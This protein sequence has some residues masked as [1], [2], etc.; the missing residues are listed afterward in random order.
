MG[1]LDLSNINF[2]ILIVVSVLN[3]IML[4]LASAKLFQILQQ[5]GYKLRGYNAW[6]KDTKIKFVGRLV[7]LSF[8]SLISVLVTN[9]LL[10]GFGEYYSYFG[11]IFYVYFSIVF[12]I[13]MS[14]IPQKAPLKQTR[15]MNRLIFTT[16]ILVVIV[17]FFMMAITTEYVSFIKYG[18]IVLTPLFMPIIVPFANILNTPME[19]IIRSGYI[20]KAKAK[21][22]RMPNLIK[23]GITGSYGKTTTKHILNV[24]LSKKYSVCMTPHSFNTPMGLTKV[25]L[26]YL[27]RNNQILI[28]EMGARHIGDIKY[29]CDL[30]KPKHAIITSVASQHLLT[31]G[32]IEN[33]AK[34]KGELVEAITDGYV[35]FNGNNIGSKK[36]YDECLKNKILAGVD[37]DGA[38][39]NITN[40]KCTNT[41]SEFNLNVDG[42]SVVCSTKLLGMGNIQDIAISAAL[43]YKL[44]VELQDI[45]DAISTLQPIQHR[46]EIINNIGG[47]TII[48]NS[49]NSSV[50]ST[51]TSLDVLKLFEGKKIIVTPGIVEMGEK[52]FDANVDFG[53]RIAEIC[54]EVVILN[55]VNK[56][57]ILQGLKNKKFD[58]NNIITAD[59]L[60]DAKKKFPEIAGEGDVILFENDLPDNYT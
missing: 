39:V 2:Y 52:E 4:C 29:L 37:L 60:S 3:S 44:G 55:L 41:G 12:I 40:V 6:L 26:K 27:K 43:A 21:L 5:S 36:M 57:A 22:K 24:M 38:F 46:L 35:V 30:I 32:S 13:N 18:I 23:I 50:E 58:E 45:A 1:I 15:R 10:D 11:L 14:K 20:K 53:E 33:V 16:S 42:K 8:L 34:A 19:H 7:M 51:Q 56:E 54:D 31:F 47:V 49:Y 59:N 28:A 17:S 9:A 48:D 25:V